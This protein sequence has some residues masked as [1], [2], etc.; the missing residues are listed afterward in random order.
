MVLSKHNN[1][2]LWGYFVHS[3]RGRSLLHCFYFCYM[4]F[5]QMCAHTRNPHAFT[6][7]SMGSQ[8]KVSQA[9][10]ARRLDAWGHLRGAQEAAWHLSNSHF[11]ILTPGQVSNPRQALACCD[12]VRRC[13]QFVLFSPSDVTHDQTDELP[14]RKQ[15]KFAKSNPINPLKKNGRLRRSLTDT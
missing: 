3:Q 9:R 5:T 15:S 7:D 12:P 8:A 4:E 13:V 10:L 14:R 11:H 2:F 6:M 1:C